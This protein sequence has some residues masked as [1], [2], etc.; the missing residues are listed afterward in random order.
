MNEIEQMYRNAG[1]ERKKPACVECFLD[2]HSCNRT[3][4]EC[5]ELYPPFTAEKQLEVIKAIS[6]RQ[7]V[8][9]KQNRFFIGFE[10]EKTKDLVCAEH[11]DLSFEI[12]LAA[13]INHLWQDI[14][15][16]EK[17]KIRE[18]LE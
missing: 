7:A 15:E 6:I 10:S 18:I 13:L 3:Y 14:T 2:R 4:D 9:L 5:P 11:L 1:V 16:D 17:Q 12:A 8:L